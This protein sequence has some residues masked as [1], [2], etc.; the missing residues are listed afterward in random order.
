M[1][2]RIGAQLYTLRDFCKTEEDFEKSMEKLEK[3]GY[4]QVQ[5]SAVGPIAPEK[6][7]D[8]CD[9]HGMII[10]C[11]HRPFENYENDIQGE[12]A[13]HKA[14]DCPV[15]GIGSMPHEWDAPLTEDVVLD[16]A[17][18]MNKITERMAEEGITFAYHNHAFEFEK[19][20]GKYVFD[21]FIENSNCSFIVDT[22][23]LAYAGINP[24]K[25]IEKLGKRAVCVHFKDLA[26]SGQNVEIA[27]VG[28]GNLEWDE[29]IN[30][31]EKAGTKYVLVEQDICKR[32]PFD[33]MEASYKFLTQK[34]FV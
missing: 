15:A 28:Q 29:I 33:C 25:Y 5:I 21:Y 24:A 30:A 18:R 10:S 22:Y 4:K 11:T 31:C 27:E 14:L 3:I 34:G 32:D 7:K 16:F 26:M 6:I 8:M 23:W 2:K 17:H 20:N 13:Y 12:I 19:I 9:R 1:D